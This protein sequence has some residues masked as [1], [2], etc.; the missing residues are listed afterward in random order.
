GSSGNAHGLTTARPP[1]VSAIENGTELSLTRLS[2]CSRASS[3]V[4]TPHDTENC[5]V[6][7]AYDDPGEVLFAHPFANGVDAGARPDRVRPRRH[8]ALDG[9]VVRAVQGA[10]PEQA[11]YDL[12]FVG[13]DAN[14]PPFGE[15]AS[16]FRNGLVDATCRRLSACDACDARA[17][18]CLSLERETIGSPVG[19]AGGVVVD[20]GEADAFEPPRGSW[21]HVSLV[22]VAID[23]HRPFAIEL[24]R[25]V[26]V[27]RL[28]R[29]VDRAGQVFVVVFIGREHLHELRVL[30]LEQA[31]EFVA[32]D[33]GRHRYGSWRRS[34]KTVRPASIASGIEIGKPV[35]S[36]CA[37]R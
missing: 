28:E 17:A 14:V 10:P 4:L 21:A 36:G 31:L 27:D 13:S 37:A 34:A 5:A 6:G 12:V 18:V 24:A 11:E 29:D 3:E 2:P 7:A 1:A 8:R 19:F 9:R 22:V 20:A 25:G 30:V 32:V 26:A 15:P 23:D 33:R 16:H 35:N